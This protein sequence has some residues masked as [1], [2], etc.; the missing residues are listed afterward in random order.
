MNFKLKLTRQH[1][2]RINVELNNNPLRLKIEFDDNQEIFT[3]DLC[4]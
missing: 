1:C 2:I 3:L 4:L